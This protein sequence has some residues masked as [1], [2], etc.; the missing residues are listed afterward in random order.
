MTKSRTVLISTVQY[1]SELRSGAIDFRGVLD[2]AKRL[3]VDGVEFR[4]VYW[5]DK[6][7][8]ISMVCSALQDLGLIATYATFTTLFGGEQANQE[9]LR[10]AVDDAAALGAVLVRVFPGHVPAADDTPAWEKASEAIEYAA[11]RAVTVAVENFVRAPGCHLSEVKQVLDRIRTPSL[12]TNLDIGNY[13]MNGEDVAVAIRTL[14]DRII[15]SHLK[16][17]ADTPDGPVATYLGGGNLPLASLL[18]EFDRLPQPVFHCFE[19]GGGGDPE[20][21]IRKSLDLLATLR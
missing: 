18:A 12:R 6:G 16:D 20:D 2:V 19:F 17:V 11:R 10:T 3:G 13:A 14:G 4:D 7:A 15:S 1:E 9:A 21:R 5:K 8:D